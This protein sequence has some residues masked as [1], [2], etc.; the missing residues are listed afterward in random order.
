M[1]VRCA[2]EAAL[3]LAFQLLMNMLGLYAFFSRLFHA[4]LCSHFWLVSF[5]NS[6]AI[7]NTLHFVTKLNFLRTLCPASA[8]ELM[9]I[10][11]KSLT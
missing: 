9:C 6:G 3:L 4:L 1:F 7:Y 2:E 8:H 10:A 5:F 11:S